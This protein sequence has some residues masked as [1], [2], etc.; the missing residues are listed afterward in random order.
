MSRRVCPPLHVEKRRP[1]FARTGAVIILCG[2]Q[3]G[4]L[5]WRSANNTGAA[6]SKI[7]YRCPGGRKLITLRDA[8][9]YL[10][11]LPKKESDL[12]EWETAIEALML[13]SHGGPTMMARIGSCER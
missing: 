8:A 10:T 12:P 3:S 1:W 4:G 6:S 7:R 2:A 11:S 9:H 13:C 5:D